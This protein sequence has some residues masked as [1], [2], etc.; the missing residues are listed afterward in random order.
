MFPGAQ[1]AQA[2]NT[3]SHAPL[4]VPRGFQG[5]NLSFAPDGSLWVGCHPKLLTFVHYAEDPANRIAPSQVMRLVP[6]DNGY[7]IVE[8]VHPF[9]DNVAVDCC[10]SLRF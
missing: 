9:A 6:P 10:C 1:S 7:P 2:P 8:E 4:S 5:D 3:V